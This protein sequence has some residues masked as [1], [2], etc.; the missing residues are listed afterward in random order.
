MVCVCVVVGEAP[1]RAPP[2]VTHEA[3]TASARS[4]RLPFFLPA[5]LAPA[6]RWLPRAA[7]CAGTHAKLAREAGWRRLYERAVAVC[8]SYAPALYNL[9]VAAGEAGDVAGA[10]A[11]YRKAVA[12]QRAYPEAWCNMGVLLRAEVRAPGQ[13]T[14]VWG[15]C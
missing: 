1:E 9:G 11:F 15:G 3:G 14:R 4:A 2:L 6:Q 8:P 13:H 7:C 12:L 5:Q 10:V